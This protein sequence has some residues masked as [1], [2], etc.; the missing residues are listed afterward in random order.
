MPQNLPLFFNSAFYVLWLLFGAPLSSSLAFNPTIMQLNPGGVNSAVGNLYGSAVAVTD[1]FLLSG[2]PGNNDAGQNAGAAHVFDAATGR[3]LRRLA[4][5]DGQPEFSF[6]SHVS[7]SGGRGVVVGGGA[8]YVFD[9]F[10]GRQLHKLTPS[11]VTGGFGYRT[12]INGDVVAV[13]AWLDDDM[14]NNSGAVYLFDLAGADAEMTE[15]FKIYA[16]DPGVDDRF[17]VSVALQGAYVA[18]GSERGDGLVAN[19]GAVYVFDSNTGLQLRKIFAN[20]GLVDD[21]FGIDVAIDG[22]HLL[23]GAQFAA[24]A[25]ANTGACYLYDLTN[26]SLLN[27]FF[28]SDGS[29]SDRFGASV[30][31]RHGRALVG[32]WLSDL[33]TVSNVGAAYLFDPRSSGPELRKWTAPDFSSSAR[34]GISVALGVNMAVVGAPNGMALGTNSGSV[35]KFSPVAGVLSMR[36]IAKS[37]DFAPGAPDT[38]YSKFNNL[39]YNLSNGATL[40]SAGL[41]GEGS[42]RNRDMGAWSDLSGNM[43]LNPLNLVAKSRVDLTALGS[44]YSGV[45]LS[46]TRSLVMNAIDRGLVHAQLMGAGVNKDNNQLLLSVTGTVVS[47]LF[48]AGNPVSELGGASVS[49]IL[50]FSQ[51]RG[52]RA[53]LAYQLK[54]AS[55]VSGL[56]S[57]T[58]ALL[59]NTATAA[60]TDATPREGELMFGLDRFGQFFGRVAMSVDAGSGFAFGSYRVMNLGGRPLQQ[61]CLADSGLVDVATQGETAPETGGA[62]FSSFT[63]ESVNEAENVIFRATVK[64]EGTTTKTNEGLWKSNALLLRKGSAPDPAL[65]LQKVSRFLGFWPSQGGMELLLVKLEGSGVSAANDCALF[66]KQEDG[67]LLKIMREGDTCADLDEAPIGVIQ[68]VDVDPISG[69]YLVLASLASAKTTN[70]ALFMGGLASGNSTT[71]RIFRLPALKIRKGCLLQAAGSSTTVIRSLQILARPDKTGAGAKGLAQSLGD[72]GLALAVEFD[73]RAIELLT[74]EP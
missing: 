57:D 69:R 38:T 72:K 50:E 11:G 59:L 52:N 70:Q 9:L 13:G 28:A 61:L 4:P 41:K 7:A 21:D 49:N 31:L 24:G 6:G 5:N 32:A 45:S 16:S 12:A 10:T 63:G 14:G 67:S 33:G 68:R 43:E 65:P 35:Y 37:G 23:V 25:S 15:T 8:V 71:Q 2:E 19:S 1:R 58:G 27:R 40:F 39:A 66:L 51:V 48:R 3:R 64:G 30:S 56:M 53:S 36:S 44:G 47:P 62:T 34:F 54:R 26:G 20:D 46:Q 60:V 18:V 73:N 29:S 22:N 42:N 17:G 74:G 55:G